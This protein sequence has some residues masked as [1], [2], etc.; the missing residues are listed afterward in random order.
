MTT[1]DISQISADK[2]AQLVANAKASQNQQTSKTKLADERFTVGPAQQ[3]VWLVSQNKAASAAYNIR[4][5]LELNGELDQ[6]RLQQALDKIVERHLP[7]RTGYE[8]DE[9]GGELLQFVHP[10][11]PVSLTLVDNINFN[12]WIEERAITPA[13]ALD[14][15][16][17]RVF[18]AQLVRFSPTHHVLALE[19][20]HIA[21]DGWSTGVLLNELK[22]CYEQQETQ[23][24][25]LKRDYVDVVAQ[26]AQDGAEQLPYW[27]AQLKDAPVTAIPAVTA[28]TQTSFAGA[29]YIR[30]VDSELAASIGLRADSL[31]MSNFMFFAAA[32]QYLLGRYN[33]TQDVVLGSYVSGRRGRDSE[34]LIGCFVNNIVLRHSWQE[35]Q[36]IEEFLTGSRQ[37]TLDAFAHQDAPFP[38]VVKAL[39]WQGSGHPLYQVGLVMQQTTESEMPWGEL[40]TRPLAIGAPHAHMD[41]E[42]YVWP[43]SQ[44][45]RLVFNYNALRFSERRMAR[46]AD[47]LVNVLYAFSSAPVQQSLL[48][49]DLLTEEE[50]Q[51]WHESNHGSAQAACLSEPFPLANQIAERFDFSRYP[52]QAGHPAV[53]GVKQPLNYSELGQWISQYQQLFV[54]QQLKPGDRVAF[55]G[56]RGAEQNALLLACVLGGF[57]YV[58]VDLALPP[59]RI[60]QILTDA[61]PA[62]VICADPDLMWNSCPLCQRDPD[63]APTTLQLAESEDLQAEF[64]L[65]Y[66]SGTTGQPK[67]VRI[68]LRA[69]KA[70]LAWSQRHYPAS[71]DDKVLQ[72]TTLNFVDGLW[73]VLDTLI[74]GATVVVVDEET[75]RDS[76]QLARLIHDHEISRAYVVPSLLTLLCSQSQSMPAVTTLFSSAEPLTETL[77]TQVRQ[78]IPNATLLNLY[79]STEVNDVTWEEVS[80]AQIARNGIGRPLDG[81]QL[82]VVDSHQRL[83]PLDCP[84]MVLIGGEQRPL[85]YTNFPTPWQVLSGSQLPLFVM[86]DI[87]VLRENGGFDL[88]GRNDDVVKIRGHRVELNEVR[89][90]LRLAAEDDCAQVLIDKDNDK[91]VGCWQSQAESEAV[92][93]RLLNQLPRYCVPERLHRMPSLPYLSNG[94]VDKQRIL[95][96]IAEQQRQ[97]AMHEVPAQTPLE[98]QL[99]Q[100]VCQVLG[101]EQCPLSSSFFDLGGS[102]LELNQLQ[103]LIM[104]E[105]GKDI[106]LMTLLRYPSVKTLAPHLAPQAQTEISRPARRGARMARNRRP[107]KSRNK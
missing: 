48:D 89:R 4:F 40:H 24:P 92:R 19:I 25:T 58:P 68:P 50:N 59:A 7:L 61:N 13:L 97:A 83:M 73:E 29:S 14:Y 33:D 88:L 12:A 43:D 107:A 66:T 71:A 28:E 6:A 62:L 11:K 80:E 56:R 46:L 81:A 3:S 99:Q 17:G 57:S 63:L 36:S 106:E 60:E 45:Y 41:L 52:H 8:F 69:A 49:V 32:M 23:L 91:L 16:Q 64:A 1:I 103:R 5:H 90:A 78:S 102:S 93:E 104:T 2:L 38:Q 98:K 100:L 27:Q 20:H 87:A 74:S 39:N 105:L 51:Q 95:L 42:L 9:Q 53:I 21:F 67:G 37:V 84:G 86:N 96:T 18:D 22:L 72:R 15:E 75:V 30:E 65:L 35:Q 47:H 34:V 31:Q 76:N 44:G 55:C 54:Q 101:L 77:L 10:A 85:G 82:W 26:Q 94:K 70:R 79:G